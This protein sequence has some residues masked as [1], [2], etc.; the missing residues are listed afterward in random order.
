MNDINILEDFCKAWQTLD[1]NLITQHLDD[2][3]RLLLSAKT[4]V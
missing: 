3:F 1:A 2:D 4:Y